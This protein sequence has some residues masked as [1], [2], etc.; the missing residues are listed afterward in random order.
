MRES[1][2][3]E[4]VRLDVFVPRG[5]ATPSKPLSATLKLRGGTRPARI[6]GLVLRIVEADR[7]WTDAHDQR[8]EE[9]D[10][11]E[12]SDRRHLTASWDRRT[13]GERR[14]ELGLDMQPH[15]EQNVDVEILVP[16]DAQF[17]T[18]CRSHTLNIQADIKGQIDPTTNAR[19]TI[20]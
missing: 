11:R 9:R 6:D 8:I 17:T 18:E 5:P 10:A 13:V 20:S 7:Y 4:G 12:L 3:A 14:I 19:I 2:G 15:D 16:S 1:L